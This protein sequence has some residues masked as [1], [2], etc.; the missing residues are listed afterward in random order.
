MRSRLSIII[1]TLNEGAT[2]AKLLQTLQTER[3]G[4]HE[5]IV[6]DGGSR[7]ETEVEARP[8]CDIWLI[9]KRGRAS[10]MNAGAA[11]AQGDVLLFLHADT[12][13]PTGFSELVRR[14]LA[15][16]GRLWGRFDVHLDSRRRPLRLVALMMN[17]RSRWSGIATGDQAIF[18]GRTAF[19]RVNGYPDI[20]LME[21]IALSKAL[22][23]LA[24]PVC[25]RA[26]V[27]TSARRWETRGVARTILTMWML[28]FAYW[29]GASPRWLARQYGYALRES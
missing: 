23:R 7:D 22:K 8:L 18:V 3:A 4:G 2:I 21:D 1:P 6:S 17:L 14:A 11:A 16:P 29:A 15:S 28:R 25:L 20:P 10:Q 27:I 13:L 5:V 12:R 19:E 24:R 26:Q 9:A